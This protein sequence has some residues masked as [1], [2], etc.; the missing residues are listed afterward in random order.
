M[1]KDNTLW[2]FHIDKNKRHLGFGKFLMEETIKI[3]RDALKSPK[4]ALYVEIENNIAQHLYEQ[5][6]FQKICVE[7]MYGRNAYRME[8]ML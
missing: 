4:I 2:N 5:F 3:F 8:L 1:L 6:G 7:E